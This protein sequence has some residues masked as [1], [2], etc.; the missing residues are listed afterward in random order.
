MND[1][2]K[3][4]LLFP[5][6]FLR[7]EGSERNS[8]LI[9]LFVVYYRRLVCLALHFFHRFFFVV[10]FKVVVGKELTQCRLVHS[11]W[12]IVSY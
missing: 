5:N 1:G 7:L 8:L 2:K 3:M 4:L 12:F 11:R 10:I 9:G 6:W